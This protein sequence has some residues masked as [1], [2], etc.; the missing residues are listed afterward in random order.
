[1]PF[2][3]QSA[4]APARIWITGELDATTLKNPDWQQ[5]GRLRATFEHEKGA[6]PRTQVELALPAGQRSFALTPPK[7]VQ[8]AAGRYVVRVELFPAAG[9]VPIQSMVDAFIPEGDWLIATSGLTARRGPSTGLQYEA[10]A[11]TRFR[12]TERIRLEVPRSAADGQAAAR[13][14]TRDGKPLNVAIALSERVDA[15]SGQRMLVADVIL[16]PL[17]QGDYAVELTVEQ[18]DRKESATYA[19][20]II[21]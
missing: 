11:D 8:L 10:T 20:R 21:P 14:L 18:G 5:G 7:D 2:R 1:V 4:A 17:A 13:L 6:S 9:K 3:L 12:R 19:F 16:A 15:D